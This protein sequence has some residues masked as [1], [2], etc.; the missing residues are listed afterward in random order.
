M[1]ERKERKKAKEGKKGKKNPGKISF[2][3]FGVV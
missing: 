3:F 2:F 1:K